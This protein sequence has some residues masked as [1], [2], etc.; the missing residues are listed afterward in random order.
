[1]LVCRLQLPGKL[2]DPAQMC[3]DVFKSQWR[4]CLDLQP[5]TAQ[6]F[7]YLRRVAPLP[8]QDQVRLQPDNCLIVDLERIANTG[9]LARRSRIITVG[10]RTD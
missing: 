2:A 5:E 4:E 7:D 9:D 10:N 3:G 1:V 6:S 8:G